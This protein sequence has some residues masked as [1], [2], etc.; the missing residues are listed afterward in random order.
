M[1]EMDQRVI[2]ELRRQLDRANE[3]IGWMMPYIG[4]MAPPEGALYDLNVHCCEN[5]VPDPGKGAKGPSLR[6]R[7]IP[8]VASSS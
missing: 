3:I 2:A 4:T 1:S 8:N 6:Q 5:N 7:R